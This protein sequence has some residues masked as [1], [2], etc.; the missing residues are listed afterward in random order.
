MKSAIMA[1]AKSGVRDL[2]KRAVMSGV[3]GEGQ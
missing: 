3:H 2:S 1:V